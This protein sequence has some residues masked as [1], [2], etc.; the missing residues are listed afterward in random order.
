MIYTGVEEKEDEKEQAQ[1][2]INYALHSSRVS[3]RCVCV[4]V[5]FG[6]CSSTGTGTTIRTLAS[7]SSFSTF[8][9]FFIFQPAIFHC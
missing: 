4:C 1:L 7:S 2:M 3:R 6:Q 9:L 5:S 8:F